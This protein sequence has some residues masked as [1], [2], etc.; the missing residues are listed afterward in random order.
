[1][2]KSFSSEIPFEAIFNAAPDAIVVVDESGTIILANHQTEILFGYEKQEL[3]DQPIEIFIPSRY[4]KNHLEHR[5]DYAV[6][7][8]SRGMGANLE[9]WGLKK[10]GSEFPVEIS[11]SPIENDGKTWITCA[12]RDVTEQRQINKL[13]EEREAQIN[14]IIE[15]VPGAIYRCAADNS[16]ELL[17]ISEA[18]EKITRYPISKFINHSKSEFV[19]LIH[20]EDLRLSQ[21]KVERALNNKTGFDIIYRLIRKDGSIAWVNERGKGIYDKSGYLIYQD[22]TF[23]DITDRKT[24]VDELALHQEILNEAQKIGKIGSWQ[25]DVKTQKIFWS[26]STLR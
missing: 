24:I 11:L 5:S 15:N 4:H 7:P 8:V 1:M 20:P 26:D 12:I 17:F 19:E 23:F 10:D 9:L 18:F 6:N 25:Y 22:G 16:S 2:P 13:K 21:L 14:N 3:L